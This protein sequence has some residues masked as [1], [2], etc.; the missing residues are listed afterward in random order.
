LAPSSTQE[1][2]MNALTT[3][4]SLHP[5]QW[6]AAVAVTLFAIAGIGAIT[7][8]I[9]TSK[10]AEAPAAQAPATIEPVAAAPVAPAPP[11]VDAT[12]R[13]PVA[14]KV[15]VKRVAP[16]VHHHPTQ[17]ARADTDRELAPLPP[18]A[19]VICDD[20]GRIQ[21]VQ[22]IEHEGE[23][24]GVGA[25]AGGV[26]GGALGNGIGQKNGRVLATVAG[27]IGGAM[28]GNHVEK[29]QKKVISYQT[30]VHF[31]DGTSRVFNSGNEPS[32]QDGQRVR[33]VNGELRP[34]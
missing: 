23:G 32:W 24:S 5:I 13:Q 20:C 9:P 19:P 22:R 16:V 11:V 1:K 3:T 27:A 28:L 2:H 7:G 34:I 33:V 6:V 21:S 12:P 10:S 8:L 18:P 29:T 14:P 15:I 17:I 31:E 30:T 26:I 4:R 25:V